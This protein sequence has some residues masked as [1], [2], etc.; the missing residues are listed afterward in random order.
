[1]IHRIALI[2]AVCSARI[3]SVNVTETCFSIDYRVFFNRALLCMSAFG[4]LN[5]LSGASRR[6]GE[7]RRGG[8]RTV[9]EE[10]VGRRRILCRCLCHGGRGRVGDGGRR[11]AGAPAAAG[12]LSQMM[13]PFNHRT[14]HNEL[15]W[16]Q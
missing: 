1:M 9:Q 2:S 4:A 14:S 11:E 13:R 12:T 7:G 3:S 15:Y 10:A 6:Q 8:A 5:H 16:I